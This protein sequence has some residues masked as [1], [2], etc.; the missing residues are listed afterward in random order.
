MI[1]GGI[2]T[3]YCLEIKQGGVIMGLG[4]DNNRNRINYLDAV[5]AQSET[6]SNVID[7]GG[8]YSIVGIIMP[9]AW[10]AA[11]ITLLSGL[12][13]DAMLDVYDQAG[14]Q[15]IIDNPA[16]N[17]FIALEPAGF[18][19]LP[20]VQIKSANAQAAART[21]KLLCRYL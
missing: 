9:A 6:L 19:A 13:E 16:A 2:A 21:L 11:D 5:I 15:V 3:C 20:F 12:S 17:R 8:Q 7:L 1:A 14:N 10:T 4:F 18:V